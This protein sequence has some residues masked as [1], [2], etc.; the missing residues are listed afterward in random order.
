M[1][2]ENEKENGHQD[3]LTLMLLGGGVRFAAFIGAL[4]ALEEMGLNIKKIVGASAGS[5]V[6]SFYAKGRYLT[7]IKKMAMEVDTE[8]FKDF[9]I[10]SLIRNKGF[11]EGKILEDWVDEML[12]G[13]RFC[14]DFKI[15]LSVIATD[16]L[17][18][19]PFVF[20][21]SNCP[22]LK[23]SR[24]IRFS[25]GIP[26]VFAYEH[27][28]NRGEKHIFIDGNLMSGIIEDRFMKEG[29]TL[30]LK[31]VSKNVSVQPI[32]TDLTLKKYLHSLLLIMLDALEKE[33]IETNRW[34]NTIIISCDDIPPTKFSITANEKEYLFEQGYQQVKKYLT[35]KWEF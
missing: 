19:T 34:K 7:E 8:K 35:Y 18:Q 22:E 31:I 13:S 3:S 26:C 5:I 15:P 1:K 33:R 25:I 28:N 9:S 21:R 4:F 2:E 24:A 29:K 10:S 30:I 32:T 17:N 12:E 23:V 20:N 14:D 16:I 6:A 27:F 11:Y